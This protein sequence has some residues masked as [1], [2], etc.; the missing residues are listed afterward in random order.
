MKKILLLVV[1]LWVVVAQAQFTPGQILTAAELNSQFALYAPL[2]GA[3]FTGPVTIPTLASTTVNATTVNATNLSVSG[4]F[5]IPA[6][7]VLPNGVTATTQGFLD[8]STKVGTTAFTKQSLLAATAEIPIASF[9]GGTYNFQTAGSGASFVI[10]ALSGPITSILSIVNPGTGY[11]V[12]DCLI[13]VGGN[14][15]A[16]VR[17]NSVS[18]GGITSLSPLYGGT[19]YTSGATL[20]GS[21]LPPGSRTANLNGVLAS[22][23]TI[24]IP[25]G[26]VLQGARRV[27]FQNNT[28]GAF[29]TTV[30]LSNGVG[31]ST[32]TGVV[33]P[34][35]T[36]NSTSV[37]LYTDGVTDVWPEAGFGLYAPIASPTFTGTVTIPG[38]ASI[39]GYA[40]LASPTFTGIPAAPTAAAGTNTTQLATTANVV[41]NFA[42]P[43]TAGYGSTTPEPVA[44]TTISATGAITPSQTAGI[45]G[46]NAANSANAGSVGE[47][48]ANQTATTPATSNVALNAASISLTAGDWD[49]S[50]IAT[51]L[52]AGTTTLSGYAEGI[53]ITSATFGAVNSGSYN[54]VVGLT[55]QA[56]SG[57]VQSTPVYR[58]SLASPATVYLVAQA[59][60][61]VSTLTV[62]G[63][64][65]ARRVR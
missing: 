10:F 23:A 41:A 34:Q 14:G 45:V 36:A 4:T 63:V 1:A 53:S 31:G 3:T 8:N 49:V 26:T 58:I 42:T 57:A 52:P 11:Q 55:F 38:G 5:T 22:N 39:A 7:T 24:I 59:T 40:L 16:I 13:V 46:T 44:A 17:V 12:G 15:D 65:R 48:V 51:Y 33:L 21:A 30:K 25:A 28:T 62:S 56:G 20:Q 61:S 64:I 19:G 27:G 29:T 6:S 2:G 43:P 47:Y 37:L 60:F 32:G 9:T 54:Q 35:G 50:G 18:G